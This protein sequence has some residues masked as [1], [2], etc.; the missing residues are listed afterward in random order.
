MQTNNELTAHV[1]LKTAEETMI[2][3]VEIFLS[4]KTVLVSNRNPQI[5]LYF[6]I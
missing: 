3:A 5:I 2:P 4:N 1:L 6:Y